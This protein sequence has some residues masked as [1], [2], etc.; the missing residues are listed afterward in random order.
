LSASISATRKLNW[1]F[2]NSINCSIVFFSILFQFDLYNPIQL[3]QF[4]F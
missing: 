2:M 3:I 1:A 4:H